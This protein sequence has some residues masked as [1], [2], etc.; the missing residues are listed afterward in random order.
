MG[1]PLGSRLDALLGDGVDAAIRAKHRRRLHRLGWDVALNP[2]ASERWA[3]A[4]TPPREGCKL[5][6]LIDG[7]QALP[8]MARAMS[9]AREFIHMTGWNITA[10]FELVRGEAPVVLGRLLAELAER[11]DVR[12]LVWAGAPI[13]A[14]HPSRA[15][16]RDE[17]ENLVRG[18]RP[19]TAS[20]TRR[21][22]AGGA[23]DGTTSPA[24]CAV[25][26]WPM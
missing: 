26:R 25:G 17:V 10:G 14:F 3:H 8:E 7:A 6:V 13:P 9:E 22:R 19:A 12:V 15:E 11:V 4:G 2:P 23:S 5:E 21:T 1:V 18:T 20:I 16:V 24:R